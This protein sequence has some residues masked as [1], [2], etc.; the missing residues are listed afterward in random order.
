MPL[1]NDDINR[2]ADAVTERHRHSI[3][4]ES[5]ESFLEHQQ[6]H[7]WLE[8]AIKAAKAKEEESKAKEQ[9]YIGLLNTIIQWSIP[10]ILGSVIYY[11]T[12]HRP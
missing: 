1:T 12:G 9:F 3:V 7:I 4:F 10:F 11:L 5:E 8:S 2:I 6:Q